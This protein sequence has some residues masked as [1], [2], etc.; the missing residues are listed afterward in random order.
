VRIVGGIILTRVGFTLFSPRPAG[1]ATDHATNDQ[2]T[3]VA[4]VPLAMPIMVGPG[5]IATILGMTSTLSLKW[6]HLSQSLRR[7]WRPCRQHTWFCEPPK[8][9]WHGSVRVELTLLRAL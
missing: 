1:A 6:G 3:D 5:A 7:S 4:F 8:L 9:Y 2:P